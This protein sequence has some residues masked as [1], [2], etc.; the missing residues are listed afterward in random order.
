MKFFVSVIFMVFGLTIHA[1]D[2]INGKLFASRSEVI[3]QNGMVATSH[4]LAT[5]I[6]IDILKKGGNA[7]DAAIACNAA[8]GLM[9]PT[10][11]G[12]G[13]DI[14]AIVWDAKTKKLYGLN[15]SGRSPASMT[16]QTLKSKGLTRIPAYGPLPVSVPGTVDG[17]FALHQRFGSTPMP[18]IL[19]PAISYAENGFPLTQLISYYLALG[20]DRFMK[21]GFKHVKETYIDQNGGSLPGEGEMYKNPFLANTYKTISQKGR[22]GFYK[23]VVAKTIVDFLQEEGGYLSVEDLANHT[24]EW[25][26]PVSVNYRGFDIWELPPN[27]QG[28]AALQMLQILEQ[29]DF[30]EIPFGSAE[31]LHLFTEAKK[32]AFEDRANYYADPDFAK[33]P[34]TTLLS[35]DYAR[36]RK[37]L[38]EKNASFY[39]AGQISPGETIYLTVADKFGNMISL[40]QSNFRGMGSGMVPPGLGFMLQDRGE[41]FSLEEGMANTYAPRKR[42]FQTIIPAFITKDGQPFV[43]FGVMGGDFQPMGHVQIVMNLIDFGMNLQEAGDAPRWEHVGSSQPTGEKATDTGEIRVESGISFETVRELVNRNHKVAFG[44]YFGGYQ[45][46]LWDP[47]NK[48]YRGASECR[49]DGQASGY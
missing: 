14:F 21:L 6:G 36:Q 46:I 26:E 20:T 9:E 10:G 32:L 31:H 41:L 8:L 30:S 1:Q 34:V 49:K 5:Q 7:I 38:I 47:I 40:I 48:V 4:P 33:I 37:S 39:Q 22:D 18:E 23:G 19:Q 16:L 45:A 3:A 15:G 12:I 42:P 2:R 44:G 17:W 24:S 25:V 13:G 28:I 35:D 27:G 29:Y 11:C 43:S